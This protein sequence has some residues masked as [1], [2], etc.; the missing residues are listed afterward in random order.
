MRSGESIQQGRAAV[1]GAV[2]DADDLVVFFG[3]VL[4]QKGGQSFADVAFCIVH[5]DDDG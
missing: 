3:N 1:F 2:V 5:G 4:S